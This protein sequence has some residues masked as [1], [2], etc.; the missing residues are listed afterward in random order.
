M[1]TGTIECLDVVSYSIVTMTVSL[2]VCE[3]FSDKV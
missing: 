3:I 2:I 1:Q